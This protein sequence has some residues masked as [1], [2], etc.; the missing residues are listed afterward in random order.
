[1]FHILIYGSALIN[2]LIGNVLAGGVCKDAAWQIVADNPST[3]Q[4]QQCLCSI[5]NITIN[6]PYLDILSN[7]DLETGGLV[8]Y[9][10]RR[11]L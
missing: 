2:V 9:T 1:M 6:S 10:I 5:A 4:D 8:T 3:P 11:P 7:Y